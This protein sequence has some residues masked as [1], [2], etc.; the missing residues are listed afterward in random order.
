MAKPTFEIVHPHAAG[1]DIHS[2]T[3]VVCVGLGQVQSFGAFTV[4]L[5][6][7][8]AHLREHGVLTVAMESTG[9]YWIP[10]SLSRR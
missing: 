9:V 1:I 7:I 10:P 4:D 2:D 3:H 5:H 6:A 8:V